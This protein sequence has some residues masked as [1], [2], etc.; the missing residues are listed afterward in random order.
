[1][2]KS[3]TDIVNEIKAVDTNVNNIIIP[4]LKDTITDYKKT[5]Q[6]MFIIILVQIGA[7]FIII[8]YCSYLFSQSN[9]KYTDF[10]SQFEFEG[11]NYVYQDTDN[12]SQINDGITIDGIERN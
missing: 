6:R 7:L 9:K 10:V 8:T 3:V 5:F 12:N 4:I 2:E 1:M 11:S